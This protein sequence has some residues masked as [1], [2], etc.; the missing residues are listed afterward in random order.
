[1]NLLVNRIG[2]PVNLLGMADRRS[3]VRAALAFAVGAA[4]LGGCAADRPDPPPYP[5]TSEQAAWRPSWNSAA[6]KGA[7]GFR[8]AVVGDAVWVAAADG[9]VRRLSKRTGRSEL[10]VK[11]P[12]RLGAG[13]GADEAIVVVVSRD[14][15]VIALDRDGQQRWSTPLQGEVVTAPVV[16]SSV[17]VVRTIDGRIVALDR[18]GG[19]VR[20]TWQR[21]L[22]T[23][24]LR[25]S[26]PPVIR[27]DTVYAGMAG[28][29]V[30]AID[31]RFGA[32]RWETVIAT[33]RGTTELER[34][35]DIVGA[36]ALAADQIC[37]IAYQGKLACLR[38]DDGRIAWSRDLA[39]SSGLSLHGETV[40]TVDAS[41]V[42]QAVRP[43]GDPLWKQDGYVRRGLTAPAVDGERVLFGDR[44]GNL[45]ALSLADGT[46]LARLTLDGT[47]FASAPA[48]V[49]GVAY[50][51]TVGGTVAAIAI[52]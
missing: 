40:I 34:L 38:T 27:G 22:P 26:T 44:F 43:A 7:P 47:P 16:A 12:A 8:P 33:P 21:T 29:R 45:T 49:D 14:G 19:S 20:W 41:D 31:L 13:V 15:D 17:I 1:M 2:R 52:P 9:N 23:L 46:P 4:A 25:Q 6:G 24:T 35:V 5:A 48:I 10:D 42:V 18:D 37:A 28:A 36:P 51:Q 11:L 3:P 30:V 50:A 32:P 39:S